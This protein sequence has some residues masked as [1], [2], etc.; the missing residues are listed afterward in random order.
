MPQFDK[1]SMQATVNLATETALVRAAMAD[2]S[3]GHA[4]R[5]E[6]LGKELVQVSEAA[7]PLQQHCTVIAASSLHQMVYQQDRSCSIPYAV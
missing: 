5:L 2:E 7:S 1:R 3:D 4:E 6:V